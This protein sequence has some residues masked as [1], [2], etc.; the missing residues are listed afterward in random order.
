MQLA[1]PDSVPNS[2]KV[3]GWPL[4]LFEPQDFRV[5]PTRAREIG[6][7]HA[8][9]VPPLDVHLRGLYPLS[10]GHSPGLAREELARDPSKRL[11]PYRHAPWDPRADHVGRHYA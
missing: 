11:L 4:H 8:D 2:S 5:K 10:D 3:E 7:R 6:H 9:V 1:R